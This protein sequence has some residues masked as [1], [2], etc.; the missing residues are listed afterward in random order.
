M[1]EFS[2]IY[3]EINDFAS[4][5]QN[6]LE[7]SIKKLGIQTGKLETAM[8]YSLL[9]EGKRI[10]PYIVSLVC[11][12]LGGQ[13]EHSVAYACALEYIH[14]YSLIHDDLPCMDNDDLRRGKPTCHKAFGYAQ[15]V[16]AGDALLTDAFYV[17]A[18]NEFCSPSNNA[19]ACKIL[20]DAA[21]SRGMVAGQ[22]LD[23]EDERKN[24][25]LN[26]LMYM[27]SLKTGKL[28]QAACL[29]GI[30]AA[31]KYDDKVVRSSF[32][33]FALLAGKIFQLRDD[34]LDVISSP[35]TLGKDIS[36]DKKNGKKTILSFMTL[37]ESEKYIEEI[38]KEAKESVADY[39]SEGKLASLIEFFAK[40]IK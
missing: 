31:G 11:K 16:L 20:S 33:K 37:S 38:A 15:A 1:S 4:L 22:I 12:T 23:M 27:Y 26:S 9:C 14:T 29:L 3:D 40:R 30:I 36:S 28:I 35:E 10:R 6:R 5:F 2:L 13:A 19:L 21:G 17:A 39:D 18:S 8:S 34:V 32:D 24:F 7:K 25:D